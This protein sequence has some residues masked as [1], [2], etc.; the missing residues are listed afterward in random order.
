MHY[1]GIRKFYV[2]DMEN[3]LVYCVNQYETFADA[4]YLHIH[5]ELVAGWDYIDPDNQYF[6][7]VQGWCSADR[8]TEDIQYE[9]VIQYFLQEGMIE[10]LEANGYTLMAISDTSD[11][12]R[13]IDGVENL[14]KA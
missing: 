2:A 1:L 7:D 6:G 14:S 5:L 3:K 8:F 4:D 13:I 11:L 12:K 9:W 10:A